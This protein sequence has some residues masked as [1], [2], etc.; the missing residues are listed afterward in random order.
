[1]GLE[2]L[3]FHLVAAGIKPSSSYCS[4]AGGGFDWVII[5]SLIVMTTSEWS[6]ERSSQFFTLVYLLDIPFTA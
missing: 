2:G 6:D 1:M 4:K 5:S 3:Y